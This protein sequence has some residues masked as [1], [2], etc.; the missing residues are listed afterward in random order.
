[1]NEFRLVLLICV[2]DSCYIGI[3][4]R[5]LK[6]FCKSIHRMRT[7]LYHSE[8]L[9]W[10]EFWKMCVETNGG[11]NTQKFWIS[12]LDW[13]YNE[14]YVNNLEEGYLYVF[15]NNIF[16]FIVTGD[17]QFFKDQKQEVINV[18]RNENFHFKIWAFICSINR[19]KF[20]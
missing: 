13:I 10:Q 8:H 9:I 7:Y 11:A 12:H 17:L 6:L 4:K 16:G 18:V 3:T 5:F 15:R 14:K 19:R 1:L 2:E 20:F